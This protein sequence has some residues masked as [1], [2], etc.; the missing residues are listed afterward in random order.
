M[1]Y[2]KIFSKNAVRIIEI[3]KKEKKPLYFNELAEKTAI[4]SKNNLLKNL[5]ILL[6]YG[7]IKKNTNKSNTFYSIR[8]E[9]IINIILFCLIDALYLNS[10]PFEVRKTIEK[11]SEINAEY[12]ILFGSYVKKE[13]DKKSDIDVLVINKTKKEDLT[14]IKQE[15]LALYGKNIHFEV[16]DKLDY[17]NRFIKEVLSYAIPIKNQLNFYIENR[18]EIF[19]LLD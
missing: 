18:N 14:K 15:C 2:Y 12:V 9:N 3:I 8:K 7:L 4:K 16:L 13:Y 10:L 1:D 19:K 5:N 11:I 6:D 17:Q